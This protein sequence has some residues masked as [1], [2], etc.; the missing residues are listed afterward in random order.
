[1]EDV[2][3]DRASVLFAALVGAIAGGVLGYLYLTESGRRFR[4]N[5]EPRLDDVVREARRLRG[6]VQKVREAADEGWRSIS[7]LTGESR[8]AWRPT[9]H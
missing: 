1:M 2:V 4:M 6:T 5:L 3:D 7:E 9:S 8:Q